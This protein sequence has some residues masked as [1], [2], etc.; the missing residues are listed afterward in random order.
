MPI[1]VDMWCES[2]F[3]T[4]LKYNSYCATL[5]GEN[6]YSS[7]KIVF[8]PTHHQYH[9][10]IQDTE[11]KKI[12]HVKL[13]VINRFLYNIALYSGIPPC[14]MGVYFQCQS[15]ANKI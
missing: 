10:K 8:G 11:L 2:V 4:K 3:Q 1:P 6:N 12:P 5:A 7:L 15:H 13:N 14:P 9:M